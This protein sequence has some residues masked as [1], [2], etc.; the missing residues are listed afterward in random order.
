MSFFSYFMVKYWGLR[1]MRRMEEE[2]KGMNE[3]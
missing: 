3:C 1:R 2:G